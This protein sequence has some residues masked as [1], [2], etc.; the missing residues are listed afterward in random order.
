MK[1]QR[2]RVSIAEV[3]ATDPAT[4]KKM[5]EFYE[6]SLGE[7]IFF[8]D[9]PDK[10]WF[11]DE[12]IIDEVSYYTYDGG[13][14]FDYSLEQYHVV[15]SV[16]TML[17]ILAYYGSFEFRAHRDSWVAILDNNVFFESEE[18]EDMAAFLW[19]V[20]KAAVTEVKYD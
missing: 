20:W 7:Y 6:S 3:L 15:P 9:Q 12:K 18:D 17:D 5:M 4:L 13:K 8:K 19:R 2:E 14:K 1:K 10:E 16:V 11:V